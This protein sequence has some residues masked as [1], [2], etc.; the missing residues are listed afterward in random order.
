MDVPGVV[1]GQRS[2]VIRNP[3]EEAGRVCRRRLVW[4]L[5]YLA[6]SW[7]VPSSG[8]ASREL[9]AGRDCPPAG[10]SVA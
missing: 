8:I 10:T 6:A 1:I 2:L 7:R 5:R 3:P 4:L 9:T